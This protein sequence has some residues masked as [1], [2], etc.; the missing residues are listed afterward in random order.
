MK[1][2]QLL[3]VISGPSMFATVNFDGYFTRFL[4][5]VKKDSIHGKILLHINSSVERT[6]GAGSVLMKSVGSFLQEQVRHRTIFMAE[7]DWVIIYLPIACSHL[8]QIQ[9][10]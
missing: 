9:V 4:I 7:K 5:P 1:E 10:N 6:P 2:P 3:Q 8:M